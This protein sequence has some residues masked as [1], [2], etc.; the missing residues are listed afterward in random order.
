MY[1]Q[2]VCKQCVVLCRV[3]EDKYRIMYRYRVENES[4]NSLQTGKHFINYPDTKPLEY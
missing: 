3:C 2:I 1:I 4:H